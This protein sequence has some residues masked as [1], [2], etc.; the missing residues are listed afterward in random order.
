MLGSAQLWCGTAP[1]DLNLVRAFVAVHETS[2]FSAAGARLVPR[3]TVS[4]AVASLEEALGVLLF[5]RTTRKVT[6]TAEGQTL[7]QRLSPSLSSMEA[8]L[9]EDPE[10]AEAPRGLLRV[11]T[12]APS[13][14]TTT[15]RARSSTPSPTPRAPRP[16]PTRASSTNPCSRNRPQADGGVLPSRDTSLDLLTHSS[17]TTAHPGSVRPIVQ[18]PRASTS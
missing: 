14:P 11:T 5:H 15:S 16:P 7:Y 8:S 10:R 1:I 18:P 6:T 12:S 2:R 9:A 13:S 3:S 4:R 17:R